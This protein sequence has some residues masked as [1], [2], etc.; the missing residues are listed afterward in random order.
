[1]IGIIVTV[2]NPS[3]DCIEYWKG[4]KP[5]NCKII[6]VDNSP[7][8]KLNN[9]TSDIEY[10]PLLY[11]SGIAHAQNTGIKKAQEIGCEYIIFFDQ[12][13]RFE[14][15]LIE[16]LKNEFNEISKVDNKIIALGPK[17]VDLAT[18][19]IYKGH[20]QD[21]ENATLKNSII[22]SGT[23]LISD[24]LHVVGG[25][26]E[27][28]FID[29]VDTEWCWR[30]TSKEYHIY[31]SA[32]NYLNHKVGNRTIKIFSYPIILSTPIRYYYQY[33]NFI[34]LLGTKYAPMDW[35]RK[36][37]IRKFIE[38]F[39]VPILATEKLKTLKYIIKG[40][41]HGISRYNSFNNSSL[42]I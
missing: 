14:P 31:A 15:D 1:M 30:A 28:L 19:E 25:M 10:I 4:L 36:T 29:Y 2:F 7:N 20:N 42:K 37:L 22:S 17:L 16:N 8:S 5:N 21:N 38:I 23:F 35:K 3:K 32:N 13:S 33:R 34:W 27:R 9:I 11:N 12:D 18:S 41:Y 39:V 6:I 26:D 24:I 40:I